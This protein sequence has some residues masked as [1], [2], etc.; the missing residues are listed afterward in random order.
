MSHGKVFS[1]NTKDYFYINFN[2]N[3]F[4]FFSPHHIFSDISE[5]SFLWSALKT[6][7]RLFFL[8]LFSLVLFLYQFEVSFLLF[9]PIILIPATSM[10]PFLLNKISF[11]FSVIFIF[12]IRLFR[13]LTSCSSLF[14]FHSS[15]LNFSLAFFHSIWLNILKFELIKYL[16]FHSFNFIKWFFIFSF[17]MIIFLNFYFIQTDFFLQIH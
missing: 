1:K 7:S 12:F 4:P 8:Y 10:S 3:V 5:A 2:E 6:I 15:R 17:K 13:L 9:L 14:S 16:I 11:S